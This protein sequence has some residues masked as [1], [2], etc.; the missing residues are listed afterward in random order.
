MSSS[1]YYNRQGMLYR[2]TS[3]ETFI[4]SKCK[5]VNEE[6]NLKCKGCNTSKVN[7][8]TR[9]DRKQTGTPKTVMSQSIRTGMVGKHTQPR[10]YP[11]VVQPSSVPR[12]ASGQWN[13]SACT[14]INEQKD[15]KC[16]ICNCA[17]AQPSLVVEPPSVPLDDVNSR[18]DAKSRDASGQWN[19]TACTFVNEQKDIK[20]S[21]C[22]CDKNYSPPAP[23]VPLDDA[24]SHDASGQWECD[25]C[26]IF[27]DQKDEKCTH[28]GMKKPSTVPPT[29]PAPT[30]RVCECGYPADPTHAFCSNCFISF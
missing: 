22:N 24:K 1:N 8:K 26:P 3:A 17:K 12:D 16:S 20:C 29:P 2:V 21:I 9:N 7:A 30:V 23:T 25:Y 13:C 27:H 11:L 28:C 6:A 10:N 14:F 4:C 15:T 19:C 5:I 18:D